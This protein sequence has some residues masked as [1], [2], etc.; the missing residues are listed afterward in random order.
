MHRTNLYLEDEK[1]EA[2]RDLAARQRRTLSDVLRQ[3]VDAY[4]NESGAADKAWEDRLDRLLERVR[5]RLPQDVSPEEI[6]ADITAARQEVRQAHRAT[7]G[8]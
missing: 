6:E 3:A 1:L 2:L 7:R 5:S 8:R 4:L